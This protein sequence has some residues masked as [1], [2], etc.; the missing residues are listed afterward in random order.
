MRITVD[1]AEILYA[2]LAVAGLFCESVEREMFRER[3]DT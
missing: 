1:R 3:M 2:L